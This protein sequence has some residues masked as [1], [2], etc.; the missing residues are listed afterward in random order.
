LDLNGKMSLRETTWKNLV[1]EKEAVISSLSS[2]LASQT[3]QLADLRQRLLDLQDDQ[4]D[5]I[6]THLEESLSSLAEKDLLVDSLRSD[7]LAMKASVDSKSYEILNLQ[8]ALG[9]LTADSEMCGKYRSEIQKLESRVAGLVADLKAAAEERA[10]SA[11]SSEALRREAERAREGKEAMFQESIGLK[12][13]N[14]KLRQAL[15][16]CLEQ[17]K[18]SNSSQDEDHQIDRRIVV[19]LLT[20]Y[21]EKGR[22]WEVMEV[23][24]GILGFTDEEKAKIHQLAT[25]GVLGTV[26]NVP[27]SIVKAP[28]SMAGNA[29]GQAKVPESES[30]LGELWI[31][32]LSD[33]I[34][35]P[36]SPIKRSTTPR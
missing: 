20:T 2:Q 32:F 13:E 27:I 33:S 11:D 9:Q 26:A 14:M 29:I 10:S 12:Q 28:L 15:Q 22:K 34:D 30:S 19:K 6:A 8:A 23:M 4:D 17:I 7:L 24:G 5:Q 36:L 16:E 21:L 31:Q 25:K 18:G 1:A 35:D 3:S